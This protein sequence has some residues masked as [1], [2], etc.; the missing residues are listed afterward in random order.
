MRGY[1]MN[2]KCILFGHDWSHAS[3]YCS[4]CGKKSDDDT[5]FIPKVQN[6]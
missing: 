6:V 4:V 2:I 5:N 3:Q 1:M